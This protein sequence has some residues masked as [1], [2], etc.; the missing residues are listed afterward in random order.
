VTTLVS[1]RQVPYDVSVEVRAPVVT[2][3]DPTVEITYGQ[4]LSVVPAIAVQEPVA[5]FT[6][7]LARDFHGRPTSSVA[8]AT[9]WRSWA[10]QHGEIEHVSSSTE[11]FSRVVNYTRGFSDAV[12]STTEASQKAVGRS[13]LEH[14]GVN[15]EIST[16]ALSRVIAEQLQVASELFIRT[17][18]Y[19]R[20]FAESQAAISESSASHLARGI[21]E[22]ILAVVENIV[23]QEPILMPLSDSAAAVTYAF[24][25]WRHN[26][27]APDYFASDYVA[28]IFWN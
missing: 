4:I 9:E 7:A 8:E 10:F 13:V 20:V 17:A 28:D 26:Y 1:L 12:L 27:A 22:Y 15:T 3:A 11:A 16:T 2:T 6:E 14:Q 21:N 5:P 24:K 18:S 25:G 19:H 23:I